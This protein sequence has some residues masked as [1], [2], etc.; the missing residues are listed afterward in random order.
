MDSHEYVRDLN[1]DKELNRGI[2][3]VITEDIELKKYELLIYS[4]VCD[5]DGNNQDSS[6]IYTSKSGNSFNHEQTWKDL[7]TSD[8]IL[9]KHAYNYYPRGRVEI[10]N[11]KADI[12]INPNIQ[13]NSKIIDE[14][15][16]EF[17]L[18]NRNIVV[19]IKIDGSRHYQCY[20]DNYNIK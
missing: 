7:V 9:R 18:D 6:V 19:S 13:K 20:L 8:T 16:V 14:I 10:K 17:G 2:F 3:W 1:L 5:K 12:Y 15:K 11:G 4:V